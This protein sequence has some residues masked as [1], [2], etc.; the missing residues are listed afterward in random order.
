MDES[1]TGARSEGPILAFSE[2][3]VTVQGILESR[4]LAEVERHNESRAAQFRGLVSPEV[5]SRKVVDA[6]AQVAAAIRAF[7]D[8]RL[9]VLLAD[10]QAESLDEAVTLSEGDVVTFLK[11]VPL[12]GG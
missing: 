8:Q 11:L 1:T 2:P 3:K 5:A 6:Q 7:N 10:R 9:I 4:I 12:V